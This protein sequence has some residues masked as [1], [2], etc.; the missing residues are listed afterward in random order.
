MYAAK[1]RKQAPTIFSARLSFL[2]RR[3]TSASTDIRHSNTD[4][5]VTSMKLSI[6]KPTSEMLPAIAPATTATKPSK[7]FH[8]MVKYS[9]LRPW[10]TI[11]GRSRRAVSLIL[12]VYNLL[13]GDSWCRNSAFRVR[14]KGKDMGVTLEA[15]C[16]CR[17][18]PPHEIAKSF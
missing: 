2:S 1:A 5:D 7:A 4:P 6:P 11:A 18:L 3:C 15:L 12:A 13:R 9:S 8:A 14:G 10:R 17:L 16:Y